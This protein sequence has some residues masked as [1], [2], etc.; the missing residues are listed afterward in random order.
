MTLPVAVGERRGR[1][2]LGAGDIL[3][4]CHSSSCSNTEMPRVDC[5]FTLSRKRAKD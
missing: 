4:G 5:M 2:I 3:S 1:E